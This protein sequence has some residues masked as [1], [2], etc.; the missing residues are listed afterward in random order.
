MRIANAGGRSKVL[1]LIFLLILSACKSKPGSEQRAYTPAES[2]AAIEASEEFKVDLFLN[3]PQVQSPVEM[4]FDENGRIYVAEMLD[5]PDDP[6]PGKPARSRIRLLEDNDGDGKYEKAVVFADQVLQVS[7]LLPWKGGLLVTAAPDIFWMKDN[8]GDGKADVRKVLYTGFPK[9]NPEHRITNLRYGL[10]NWIYA[11]NH[12]NA[13]EIVSP[14]H[15]ERKPLLIRGADFRFHMVRDEPGLSSGT[16]QYGLTF[17]E[18]GNEFITENTVHIRHVVLPMQYI[19]RAPLMD[20]PA[21][22][23]DI[24]DH[25][26]PSAPMFPL[27]GP[28]QWRVERTKLRQQRYDEQGLDRKE[29][30]G[31]FFSGASGG[32]AYTGD[33]FPAEYVGNVFTGDVSGNLVH[34]DVISP[35]GVTF[36]ASRS[37]D[38]VEF[39]ASKDV[40]FRPCNFANAPDGNLYMMD[41]Y[42]LF[43]ETPESIPEEIKKGMDFYAGDTMGRIYRISPKTP[44]TQRDLRPRL[45]AASVEELVRTLENPNGWHR[46]TAQRLI[47]DRQDKTAVPF[48]KQLIEQTTSP[49]G[50]IHGL[51][52]LEGLSAL[53]EPI[54]LKALTDAN[55]RVREHALRLAEGFLP[56]SK[57]LAAALLR[58]PEDADPRVRLQTA[59]TLGQLRDAS[60]LNALVGMATKHGEDPWFRLAILSSVADQASAFFHALRAARPDLENKELFAQLA[61]LIATKQRPAELAKL[62][63]ALGNLKSPEVILRGLGKGL[64]LVGARNLRVPNAE[65]TLSPFL[66]S[67]S[68]ELQKTAW[69]AARYFELRAILQRAVGDSQNAS[70]PAAKRVTA[71]RALRGGQFAAVAPILRKLLE[72]PDQP[73]LQLAAIDSLSSFDDASI[74]ASLLAPWKGF[75][76]EVRQQALSALMTER[77]RMKAALKALEDG[78]IERTM[79]DPSMRAKLYDH[80]E[81]AVADRAR[82]FFKQEADERTAAVAAYQDVLK[83]QGDVNRG[84]DLYASTCAKCHSP[85]NG[86]PRIGADLSGINNKTKEELLNSI[87]NPS[88]AIDPRFINY[89]ITTRD[90]RIQDGLLAN[91]TAGAVTLRNTD[92][93][94]PILRGNIAE[95]RASTLSLMPDGFE[96]SL[97][98]QQVADIIAY[99]RGGL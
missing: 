11:S 67:P 41:V 29:I 33:A 98:K 48:L 81:P 45:G 15:P 2:L 17:D 64:K 97:S 89:I 14:D 88:A 39:L 27:T 38:G 52:T 75:T 10:D 57:A 20:V 78:R 6:P 69:D 80:P 47:V 55:P 73:E 70:L 60:A 93:D 40:W 76:P 25:G 12:G 85:Q 32:T 42:R 79:F 46:T 9:V 53:E 37:K 4:V 58:M 84:R 22:A 87:L 90:G 86:R 8:D 92:G 59:F 82:A 44:R 71:V 83:L 5:Y 1:P 24:S 35:D 7:G 95:I 36:K 19:A 21:Y 61:S 49:V 66:N 43:I 28:Q 72:Q 51:W 34:R 3:E 23:Q 30:V 31:G 18:W 26:R 65:A 50:R 54:V 16:A 96:K 63:G 68:E 13:G 91:E 99:L 77:E 62:L 56:K 74:A 94:F